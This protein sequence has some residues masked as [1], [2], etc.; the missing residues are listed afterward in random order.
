MDLRQLRQFVAVAEARS[1]RGAA[2]RLHVSQP[3]LSVAVRRLEAEIG[4]QLFDRSRQ[5]VA[6]TA[7]GAALL[8]E[9]RGVLAAADDAVEATRRA[10]RGL[11]G[12]LAFSFVPSAA[13]AVVPPLLRAFR[14]AYPDVRLRLSGEPSRRQAEALLRGTVDIGLVVPPLQSA[15]ARRFRLQPLGEE[16]LVLALPAAHP[17]ASARRLQLR[18]LAHERFVAF[19]PQEGPGFEAVIASACRDAGFA[20]DVVQ[21]A[22]QMQTLLILVAGGLGVALVPEA[23][24]AVAVDGAVFVPLRHGRAPL[25]YP[26][27][28]AWRA[29]NAN[30]ALAL[31][32]GLA[33][34]RSRPARR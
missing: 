11:A 17:L 21:E 5:H 29:D 20:P 15:S 33:E 2:E 24:R 27:A 10:A 23:M 25:R 9:A 6:L 19:A 7:A 16:A 28:L 26:L 3:P 22:A 13:L 1:F 18:D 14:D 30:P 8:H 12:S 4:V 31:F 34:R 32:A